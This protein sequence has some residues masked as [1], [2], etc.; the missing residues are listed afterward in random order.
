MVVESPERGIWPGVVAVLPARGGKGHLLLLASRHT[1]ALVATLT[2][3]NGL[4]QV[5]RLWRSKGSPEFFEMAMNSE[6]NGMDMVRSWPVLLRP[7]RPAS[8][9]T[10][11]N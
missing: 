2:S 11:R 5:E 9:V 4:D 3:R 10:P 6:M 1:S 7:F 8:A